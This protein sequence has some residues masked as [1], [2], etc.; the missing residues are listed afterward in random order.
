MTTKL[1]FILFSSFLLLPSAFSQGSLTPPGAPAPTMKT[2]DQV[3]PRTLIKALPFT[4]SA[5]GSYYLTANLVATGSGAGITIAADNVTLD[6]NGFALIGGG[7]G[8]VAG[9]NVPAPQKNI[10]VRNGTVRGWTSGGVRCDNASNSFFEKLRVSNNTGDTSGSALIAGAGSTI[11]DCVAADNPGI[12]GIYAIN[13]CTVIGC[14]ATGNGI[15]NGVPGMIRAGIVTG[16]GCTVANCTANGHTDNFGIYVYDGCNVYGCSVRGNGAG[17]ATHSG[18]LVLG[19]VCDYNGAGDGI[20][21]LGVGNRIEGNSCTGNATGIGINTYNGNNLVIRNSA[22]A[23]S[24]HNYFMNAGNNGNF[25]VA[26]ATAAVFQGN[27]GGTQVSTD[28]WA[29]IAY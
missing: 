19:N 21:T 4:I 10:C 15:G 25:V 6:L 28:P 29:N 26:P 23:N 16:S 5:Q 9:V 13:F 17:I 24:N 3:E 18:C 7:S 2:L 12:N 1:V 20:A 14:T 8:T 11:R 27:S 22:H